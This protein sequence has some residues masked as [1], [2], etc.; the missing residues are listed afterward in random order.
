MK[1]RLAFL[2]LSLLVHAGL[3]SVILLVGPPVIEGDPGLIVHYVETG[4][5]PEAAPPPTEPSPPDMPEPRPARRQVSHSS[6]ETVIEVEP[7]AAPPAPAPAAG[8]TKPQF[9]SNPFKLSYEVLSETLGPL[10]VEQGPLDVDGMLGAY[11]DELEAYK[12]VRYGT[13]DPGLLTLRDGMED[14]WHPDFGQI[15]DSPL[16]G[17]VGKM[18]A[19]WQK[20]AQTY[21]HTGSPVED[22]PTNQFYGDMKPQDLGILDTYEQLEKSDA[23][24]TRARLVVRIDF[25]GKG[26]WKV[27]KLSG[28]GYSEVDHAA[29]EAVHEALEAHDDL[30][31][32][33]EARTRWALEADFTVLP[34][35]PVAGFTFDLALGVF[36][37]AYPLKKTVRRRIKLLAVAL[38]QPEA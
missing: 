25:D 35:L 23:F 33:Y 7:P 12:T 21:G 27:E 18:L 19:S 22:P 4:A 3:L 15:H 38:P 20:T 31:P 32:G 6:P 11:F 1:K 9:R 29:M 2:A 28:S 37:T 13:F 10:E 14:F 5:R 17:A 26:G 24:T 30:V 34:P 16:K 36:E 8:K